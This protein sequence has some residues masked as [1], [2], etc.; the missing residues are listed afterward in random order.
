MKTSRL[1]HQ[2]YPEYK[3]ALP[4]TVII[5]DKIRRQFRK[6]SKSKIIEFNRKVE[7]EKR[8]DYLPEISFQGMTR[9]ERME[10]YGVEL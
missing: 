6:I 8:Y 9:Q 4:E 10:W 5:W 2:N 1:N 7:I 3:P